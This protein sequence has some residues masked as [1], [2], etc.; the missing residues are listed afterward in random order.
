MQSLTL[1]DFREESTL[2][3]W[4]VVNDGVMGGLSRGTLR[5]NAEGHGVFSGKVSLGNN[6]G[7]ASIRLECGKIS[8]E[9]AHNIVLK[10]KGDGKR[11]QFRIRASRKDYYAYI[12]YFDT[13][14][15]WEKIILPLSEFYPNFRG[16]KLNLPDFSGDTLEEV[17]IL[18]GNKKEEEFQLHINSILLE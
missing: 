4:F 3:K 5:V 9:K 10:V 11:Y 7:F 8:L 2:E 16:R 18:I 12:Q 13:S 1:F 15:E 6:G 17:G 14:G